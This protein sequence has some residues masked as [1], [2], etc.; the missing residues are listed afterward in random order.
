L[1]KVSIKFDFCACGPDDPSIP[2]S[3]SKYAGGNSELIAAN[4]DILYL[5]SEG[6]TVIDGRTDQHPEYVTSYWKDQFTV[7]G[8]TGKFEGAPGILVEDDYN[9]SLDE[10]SHHH[11]IGT[12]TLVK[13]K[14]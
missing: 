6:G 2:G 12:L 7:T 5:Y 3:D 9:S 13:G 11:W 10:Y 4:G 1:G 8:G 14:S